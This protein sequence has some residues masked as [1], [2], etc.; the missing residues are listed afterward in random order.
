MIH[1]KDPKKRRAM[2]DILKEVNGEKVKFGNT[3]YI[4]IGE[5][6][7]AMVNC[8]DDIVVN[9]EVE[10]SLQT[11]IKNAHLEGFYKYNLFADVI[12]QENGDYIVNA[13]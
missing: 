2:I 6:M 8:V 4:P 3:R 1:E 11:G 9:R 10:M 7:H 13:E 12:E 5:E